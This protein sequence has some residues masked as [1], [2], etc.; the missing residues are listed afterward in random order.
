MN[1]ETLNL[2]S[3]LGLRRDRYAKNVGAFLLSDGFAY[4]GDGVSVW[5]W[6]R[7]IGG[8]QV[9]IAYICA[10]GKRRDMIGRQGVHDSAQD[11]TVAGTGHAMSN[12]DGLTLSFWTCAYGDKV[13][14]GSGEGYR[15]I[16]ADRILAINIQRGDE[17]EGQFVTDT[18]HALISLAMSL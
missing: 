2:T 8:L 13:N 12:R 14:T 7:S 10:D 16:R 1:T 4:I 9:R 11:G 15:T 5:D 6:M 17:I 18:G 3:L